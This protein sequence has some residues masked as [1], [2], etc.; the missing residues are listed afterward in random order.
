[1][2][3]TMTMVTMVKM[4]RVI[5]IMMLMIVMTLT[6]MLMT[7]M[8]TMMTTTVPIQKLWAWVSSAKPYGLSAEALCLR[9]PKPAKLTQN[10][11]F[12]YFHILQSPAYGYPL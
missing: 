7:V 12:V 5:V 3:I 10:I 6:L 11:F 9:H 2:M 8:A 4:M 1:M